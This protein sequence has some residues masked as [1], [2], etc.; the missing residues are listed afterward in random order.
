LELAR[1]GRPLPSWQRAAAAASAYSDEMLNRFRVERSIGRIPDGSL[2][3]S[4]IL[5][6]IVM[7]LNKPALVLTD[8]GGAVGELGEDFLARFPGS[9]YVVVENPTLVEMIKE[10][11]GVE[12]STTIPAECDVFF[13]SG[14]LQ[15]LEHP[16]DALEAGF[17]SARLAVVLVRNSFCPVE[18]FR[19]QR[20]R[21]FPYVRPGYVV[22]DTI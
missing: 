22:I 3:T 21:L 6:P 10:R 9:K 7:A 5:Y 15:Y 4:N 1:G 12:F 14:T 17:S 11:L 18:V 16:L 8:L 2:L 19:V 20:T 13:S